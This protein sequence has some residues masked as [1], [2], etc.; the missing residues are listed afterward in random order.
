MAW[1]SMCPVHWSPASLQLVLGPLVLCL[2]IEPFLVDRFCLAPLPGK[3][4]LTHQVG[5]APVTAPLVYVFGYG[6]I[7]GDPGSSRQTLAHAV[8]TCCP[9]RFKA[10]AWV[11]AAQ[12][13][14]AGRVCGRSQCESVRRAHSLAADLRGS[15]TSRWRG[16]G[17][18]HQAAP[19]CPF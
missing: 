3:C 4:A 1:A 13:L 16:G 6:A 8:P 14:T 5:C 18:L 12:W 19:Y 15:S 17:M 7:R 2:T 10:Q 11:G 9:T